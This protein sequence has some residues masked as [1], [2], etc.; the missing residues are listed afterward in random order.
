M[1]SHNLA[2]AYFL[3]VAMVLVHAQCAYTRIL[4]I[5]IS[6]DCVKMQV[7]EPIR[8]FWKLF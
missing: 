2:H 3:S 5:N 6:G 7:C 4:Y 8:R 1:T